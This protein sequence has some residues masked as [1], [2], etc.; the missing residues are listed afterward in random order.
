MYNVKTSGEESVAMKKIICAQFKQE[1][2][3]YSPNLSDEQA[4][5]EREDIWEETSIRTHFTGTKT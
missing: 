5:R 3:R 1:T 4:Y 2:N